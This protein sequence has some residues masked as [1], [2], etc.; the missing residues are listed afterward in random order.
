MIILT[1]IVVLIVA[2]I[3]YCCFAI[4]GRSNV[5]TDQWGEP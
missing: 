1:A 5:D 2:F 4:S 3:V